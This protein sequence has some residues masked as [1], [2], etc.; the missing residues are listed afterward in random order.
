MI[1]DSLRTILKDQVKTLHNYFEIYGEEIAKFALYE[2]S[3]IL[4]PNPILR[5]LSSNMLVCLGKY[6]QLN[7]FINGIVSVL[8]YKPLEVAYKL[9]EVF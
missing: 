2:R 1:T 3:G 8:N 6:G 5:A 7:L 4:S 9:N